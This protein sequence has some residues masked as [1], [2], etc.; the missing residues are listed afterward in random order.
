VK[1]QP[2]RIETFARLA[3]RL[4]FAEKYPEL[5]FLMERNF[6]GLTHLLEGRHRVTR[7]REWLQ[8]TSFVEVFIEGR[9]V[10]TGE[11]EEEW[12]ARRSTWRHRFRVWL[13]EHLPNHGDRSERARRLLDRVFLS[14]D[15]V[16][17]MSKARPDFALKVTSVTTRFFAEHY[18]PMLVRAWMRN[19]NSVLYEET[20]QN[21]SMSGDRRYQF[22][23]LNPVLWHLFGEPF[24]AKDL[25]IFKPVGDFVSDELTRLRR[26]P[27]EDVHRKPEDGFT[28]GGRWRS[29]IYIGLRV[30]D[31]WITESLHR[32]SHWHGWLMYWEGAVEDMT[33]NLAELKGVNLEREFPTGYHYLMYEVFHTIGSWI[34]ESAR[35]DPKLDSVK[36]DYITMSP[37]TIA[38]S[39]VIAYGRCLRAVVESSNLT[40]RF[41]AYIF[42]IVL[43]RYGELGERDDMRKLYEMSVLKGGNK[44]GPVEPYHAALRDVL[45]SVDYYRLNGGLALYDVVSSTV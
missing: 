45:P 22:T 21:Q 39:A 4:L 1:L 30:F 18:V 12:R 13:A 40:V 6:D 24:H 36:I 42:D 38:K 15:F 8:P 19:P 35:L 10:A 34:V 5:V 3:E 20:Y 7:L 11:T 31:Y 41:K 23:E 27:E 17:Y 14:E 26:V 16:Y 29:P 43:H 37:G 32:G 2:R 28:D 25:A 44:Y 9:N 33:K